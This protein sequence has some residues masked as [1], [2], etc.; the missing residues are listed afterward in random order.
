VDDALAALG[1]A[2]NVA[3]TVPGFRAALAIAAA[4]DLVALVPASYFEHLREP[5]LLQA[6]ALPV[7][8]EGIT[9]SQMWHPRQ[10]RDPG[11]RW[12][13]ALLRDVCAPDNPPR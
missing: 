13:R 5:G 9:I 12:L 10:D 8:A 2:R 7:Q 4:T 11:H 1:L 6:F 3:V